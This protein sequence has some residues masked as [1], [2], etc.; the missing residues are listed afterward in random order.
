MNLSKPL[1]WDIKKESL[2]S[3]LLKPFTII[4]RINN[5]LLNRTNKIKSN[6][7]TSICV[8]NIYLGGTGKT[9][10]TIK[11]Y[12]ILKKINKKTVVAKKYYTSHKDEIILLKKETK[13]LTGNTRTEILSKAI[14]EKN[15]IVIFDD[16]LQDKHV[17]YNL[18]FVCFDSLNWIGNGNL[19][20][21]GP[22]RE[23]LESLKKYDAVFFKIIESQNFKAIR[24]IRKINP[25]IKI[26]N[27]KY[28]IKNLNKLSLSSKYL[29]FSGIGNPY[30]FKKILQNKKIK[31]VDQII[32]S[33]HYDYTNKEILKI[34]IKAKNLKS[35]IIT[36]EK[37]FVKIPK[38]YQNK[39]NYLKIGVKINKEQDLINFLRSKINA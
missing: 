23:N 7:I 8:G 16:G 35:K 11:L 13:L 10:L 36:T 18:K 4:I 3:I 37:D 20:P 15:E 31:I 38:K 32:F 25:K 28:E 1:F 17:D 26:F 5:F 24:L 34:I 2:L 30:S 12:K 27:L 21:A 14:K 6:K 29:I 9:P 39:F 22:L 19:L 33:D